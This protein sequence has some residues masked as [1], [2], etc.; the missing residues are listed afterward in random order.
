MCVC[1]CVFY[2]GEEMFTPAQIQAAETSLSAVRDIF[3]IDLVA[4]QILVDISYIVCLMRRSYMVT[5]DSL[6]SNGYSY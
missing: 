6:V 3:N 1:V 2:N 4:A 5:R